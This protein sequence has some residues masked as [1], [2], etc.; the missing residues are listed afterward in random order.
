MQESYKYYAFISYKHE[1]EKYAKWLHK[2]L[3]N[4]RIPIA[5][6]N[7]A[8]PERAN[9]IFRDQTDLV[10]GKPLKA[11]IN[12]KL[13]KSKYLIV[14]CSRNLARESEYVDF[15]INTFREMGREDRI[16][17]IIIDGEPNAEKPENE[18]F[19]NAIKELPGEILAADSTKDGRY[20][21]SLKILAA[22][23]NL[24][25]DDLLRRDD[26]RRKKKRLTVG[27]L[28]S[29]ITVLAF[30][31]TT[32]ICH[33]GYQSNVEMA[34]GAYESKEYTAAAEYAAKALSLPGK[35]DEKAEA[36]AILR[37]SVIYEEL[38]KSNN[39][40]HKEYEIELPNNSII[41][42]GESEDGTKVA[43]SDLGKVWVYDSQSKERLATFD[44]IS[45]KQELDEYLRPIGSTEITFGKDRKGK[46]EAEKYSQLLV[47]GS[48]LKFYDEKGIEVCSFDV[49]GYPEW[50]YSEDE[51][52]VVV[53][54]DDEDKNVYV[55]SFDYNLVI[56][57]KRIDD[58]NVNKILI[59]NKG[60]YIFVFSADIEVYDTASGTLVTTLVDEGMKNVG[61]RF[62]I[63]DADSQTAYF[64]SVSKAHKYVFE[65]IEPQFEY[66]HMTKDNVVLPLKGNAR[67]GIYISGDG[68]KFLF[69]N[70]YYGISYNCV[71]NLFDTDSGELIIS[72]CDCEISL[73]VNFD[74]MITSCKKQINIYDTNKKKTAF[75]VDELSDIVSVAINED[76]SYAGYTTQTGRVVILENSGGV[77]N[78]KKE[79]LGS[80]FEG[81]TFI[82]AMKGD[83]CLIY[84][85]ERSYAYSIHT[86]IRRVFSDETIADISGSCYTYKS[87]VTSAK[88]FKDNFLEL[89]NYRG[90]YKFFDYETGENTNYS[91]RHLV[92]WD[93]CY[94]KNLIVGA[95]MTG[96]QQINSEFKVIQFENGESKVLYSYTPEINAQEAFFD[97]TGEYIIF[98]GRMDSSEV[99]E[100]ETGKKLFST[101]RII[102]IHDG[103]IYDVSYDIVMPDKLPSSRLCSVSEF[104]EKVK[105]LAD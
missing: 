71:Y 67:S 83:Q 100:V 70:S 58:C 62:V 51:S 45:E 15:E 79:L 32:V 34:I 86:D 24:D 40:F 11:S 36:E 88:F 64:F 39:Q 92:G 91:F 3:E 93:Y 26:R 98:T 4:Y 94:D 18:C 22:M 63:S 47:G 8:I 49:G 23:F 37:G 73:S 42:Y 2:R 60:R 13:L 52:F 55:Y 102:R 82:S 9:P 6:Q 87:F 103:M 35:K 53:N 59:S 30:V 27:F 89:M 85:E 29:L 33:L 76:G 56:P 1:D 80:S 14:I 95:E 41:F 16:I 61:E 57:L 31:V 74:Y 68:K 66:Y 5:L 44:F 19:S 77:Y 25:A 10:P 90:D 21:A 104:K 99:I 28:C 7:T 69:K 81:E 72:I 12:E 46:T 96:Q 20:I 78:V 50:V 17:P 75:T 43:F 97:N 54:V 105:Q 38:K 65:D 84:D 48:K 101:D